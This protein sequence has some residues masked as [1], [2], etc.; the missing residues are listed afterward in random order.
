[1]AF[2]ETAHELLR[3][4]TKGIFPALHWKE[5]PLSANKNFTTVVATSHHIASDLQNNNGI[6]HRIDIPDIHKL[7]LGVPAITKRPSI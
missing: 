1:M 2:S 4:L 3:R 6:V 7:I 5:L